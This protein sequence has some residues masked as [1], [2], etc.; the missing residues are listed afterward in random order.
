MALTENHRRVDAKWHRTTVVLALDIPHAPTRACA[1]RPAGNAPFA[2]V[3][4]DAATD[5]LGL[6]PR[7]A[8]SH[9]SSLR[10][11]KPITRQ[12]TR[13]QHQRLRLTTIP[14]TPPRKPCNSTM[15][16]RSR[17]PRKK[18]TTK[19]HAPKQP[20]PRNPQQRACRKDRKRCRTH[21]RLKHPLQRPLPRTPQHRR[22][23]RTPP[24][25]PPHPTPHSQPSRCRKRRCRART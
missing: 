5:L 7:R 17:P 18:A 1:S 21:P 16:M 12:S 25:W 10:Q 14:P 8:K 4:L 24:T 19:R 23:P 13:T 2:H 9:N 3:D 11:P 6:A 22:T 20:N 15:N